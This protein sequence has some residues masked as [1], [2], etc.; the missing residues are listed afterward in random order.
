MDKTVNGL[1][2]VSLE[3]YFQRTLNAPSK[4]H[5]A[6]RKLSKIDIAHDVMVSIEYMAFRG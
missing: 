2:K 6:R 5:Q 3:S 4:K 1:V